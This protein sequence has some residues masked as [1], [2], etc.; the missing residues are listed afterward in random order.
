MTITPHRTVEF[1][2]PTGDQSVLEIKTIEY[3]ASVAV[4]NKF[5]ILICDGDGESI[6]IHSRDQM[7]RLIQNLQF[8]ADNV[9]EDNDPYWN[10]P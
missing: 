9:L 3:P 6:S 8:V 2:Y 10:K 5:S 4:M 7:V 1:T